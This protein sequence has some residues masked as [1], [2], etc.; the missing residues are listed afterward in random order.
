MPIA[1]PKTLGRFRSCCRRPITKPRSLVS[2]TWADRATLH[3]PGFDHWVSFR[4]QGTYAPGKQTLNVNGRQVP[5][6]KYMTDELTEYSTQ[7][8]NSRD[9]RSTSRS[10]CICHT[11][12]CMVCTIQPL[13]ISITLSE[14]LGGKAP[15]LWRTQQKTTSGKPMWVQDQR[16]SWHGV[17]FPYHGRAK[18]VADRNVPALLRNDLVDR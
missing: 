16:N 15:P 13:D 9:M 11:R 1:C 10:C 14:C 2:G 7:W 17:E 5:R 6:T 12:A 3:S 8:L 18:S 4:G